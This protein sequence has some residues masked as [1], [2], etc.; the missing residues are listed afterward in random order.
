MIDD[1]PKSRVADIK[2]ILHRYQDTEAVMLI[3][4]LLTLRREQWRDK[5][6]SSENDQVRGRAKECKELLHFL[7]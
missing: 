4:E 1:D 6:E 5:L 2:D 3:K 7:S